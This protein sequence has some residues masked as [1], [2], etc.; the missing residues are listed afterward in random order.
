MVFLSGPDAE[1]DV[2]PDMAGMDTA[3]CTAG[4]DMDAA[5]CTVGADMDMATAVVGKSGSLREL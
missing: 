5:I 4:V 1:A 2:A 3:I